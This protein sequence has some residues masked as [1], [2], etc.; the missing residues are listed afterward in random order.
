LQISQNWLFS[1]S[2]SEESLTRIQNSQRK[3][4]FKKQNSRLS[5]VSPE[6]LQTR[7]TKYK[8]THFE[9]YW[10]WRGGGG[11]SRQLE[12][13][14][15]AVAQIKQF[16]SLST[17]RTEDSDPSK[18]SK[19]SPPLSHQRH[20]QLSVFMEVFRSKW[21]DDRSD[22]NSGA[23]DSGSS[24]SVTVTPEIAILVT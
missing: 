23:D 15:F 10:K 24:E 5:T 19:K 8:T 1:K 3:G 12:L 21:R 2:N 18:I 17:R 6:L 7:N 16:T 22:M 4:T 11:G 20:R 9:P 13:K 14:R